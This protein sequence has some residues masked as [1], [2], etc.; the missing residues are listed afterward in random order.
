MAKHNNIPILDYEV[1]WSNSVPLLIDQCAVMLGA[2]L[3]RDRGAES[4]CRWSSH[5]DL[6]S[7]IRDRARQNAGKPYDT[8]VCGI[9]ID[10]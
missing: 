4:P 3:I 7:C 2:A 10:C 8:Y 1:D 6:C 5:S 9:S